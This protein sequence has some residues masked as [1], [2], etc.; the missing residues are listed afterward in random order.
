LVRDKRGVAIRDRTNFC[1]GRLSAAA[2]QCWEPRLDAIETASVLAVLTRDRLDPDDN[3][4]Q[5]IRTDRWELPVLEV[6][7]RHPG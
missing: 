5:R 7:S 3:Y 1:V 2:A 6:V 4:R